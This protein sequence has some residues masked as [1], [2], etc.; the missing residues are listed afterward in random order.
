M[1]QVSK[2]IVL[3]SLFYVLTLA[4]S[5]EAAKR[6][7]NQ[8]ESQAKELWELAI[9]AKGGREKLQQVRAFAV[10]GDDK[11][12]DFMVFP[13]R[14]FRWAD[15][16]PS[17][18]GLLVEMFN[19]EKNFGFTI[20]GDDP[21]DV[22]KHNYLNEELL[23][24]FRKDQLYF[25]LETQWLKPELLKAYK[26]NL[27]GKRVDVVEARFKGFGYPFRWR[28]FLDEISHLPIRIGILSDTYEG[29]FDWV[30]LGDYREIKGIKVPTLISP[31]NGSWNRI[32]LEIN[33]DY[34]ADFFD[35][36]PD[37]KAGAFQWRKDGKKL[38]PSTPSA[39]DSPQPLTQE[40]IAQY[41][42]DLTST[43]SEKV[44][45]A[46]RELIRAG[47]QVVPNLSEATKSDDADLRFFAAAALLAINKENETGLQTMKSL[48]LNARLMPDF[49][50]NAAFRLMNSDK[51]I[52]ELRGLLK[53]K[54]VIVRRC[55]IFAFDELTE[56]TEIPETVIPAIPIL[57]ELKKDK[58]IVVRGMAEE[59]LEQI[60]CRRKSIEKE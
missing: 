53:Y 35:K 19:F 41:I 21:P 60:A 57:K 26:D 7:E 56:L 38:I 48:L 43:D 32:L 17:K 42:K 11:S 52:V 16:R 49:R 3:A 5:G 22:R 54:D 14:F 44:M 18:F 55:V 15:T 46:G 37:M 59:I 34:Q 39:N 24:R 47:E 1:K 20:W 10:G 30:D 29:M 9:A 8:A 33:P 45:F 23:S 51:G 36:Q 50:Q 12:I 31:K 25:F 40:Q 6:S 4:L 13:D 2:I 27:N 58:D 28:I